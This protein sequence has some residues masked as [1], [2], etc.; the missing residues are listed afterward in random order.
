VQAQILDLLSRLQA[1]LGMSVLMITH[2]LGVVAEVA[3]RALVMYAGRIAEQAA[4]TS[5]FEWPRHPYTAGL[6]ESLPRLDAGGG[7]DRGQRLRSIEG[8][9]PDAL[10]FPSGCRFH[11]RCRYAFERCPRE[12]PPLVPSTDAERASE[13][14]L[15]ACWHTAAHPEVSYLADSIATRESSVR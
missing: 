8:S 5:L 1:E 3:H 2:D 15:S 14:H 11:P 10:S 9:V 7:Y 13:Q 12:A 4:V 6:L